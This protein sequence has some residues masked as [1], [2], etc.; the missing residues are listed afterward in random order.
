MK[1]FVAVFLFA[2]SFF[3]GSSSASAD[4]LTFNFTG[5]CLDCTNP[6]GTL[7]LQNYTLG[8]SI[9]SSNFVSFAY[10][11]NLADVSV[12]SANLID[13][14]GNL[15]STP[16]N[17]NFGIQFGASPQFSFG[18][19]TDGTWCYGTSTT[20][21]IPCV[22]DLCGGGTIGID[23]GTNG[24]FALE[25]PSS[26]PEPSSLLLLGSGLTALPAFRRRLGGCIR[27]SQDG[28]PGDDC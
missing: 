3:L 22:G 13:I 18:L 1:R 5:D 12:T 27:R 4:T 16:G 8:E 7:V 19:E 6:Q 25:T 23:H 28:R 17:N 26:V 21:S 9:T 14:E 24:V 15:G 20:C 11:S 10:T 2:C